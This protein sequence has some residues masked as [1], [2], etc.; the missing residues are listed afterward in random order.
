M[1]EH[2]TLMLVGVIMVWFAI[3]I[4]GHILL[5]PIAPILLAAPLGIPITKNIRR[6]KE[7]PATKR[8]Q[9]AERDQKTQQLERELEIGTENKLTAIERFIEE[10][11]RKL[12]PKD[13]KLGYCGRWLSGGIHGDRCDNQV[14]CKI[15]P[16][17]DRF[18][19]VCSKCG[20]GNEIENPEYVMSIEEEK[21]ELETKLIGTQLVPQLVPTHLPDPWERISGK[22]MVHVN[23]PNNHDF[24]AHATFTDYDGWTT[25]YD[26]IPGTAIDVPKI[27]ADEYWRN[28]PKRCR[29]CDTQVFQAQSGQW[30]CQRACLQAHPY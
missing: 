5:G 22:P 24:N 4:F 18:K 26:F 1:T 10:T 16:K 23:V 9:Q 17:G 6:L 15:T 29:H 8:L 12:N 30:Y 25:H 7:G 14:W 20:Q 27:V 3:V 11:D 21:A 2:P 19:G 28:H 13:Y